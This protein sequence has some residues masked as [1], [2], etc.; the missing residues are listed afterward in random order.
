M[1]DAPELVDF[2]QQLVDKHE[3]EAVTMFVQVYS[4]YQTALHAS[5]LLDFDDLILQAILLLQDESSIRAQIQDRFC[6]ISVDEYQDTNLGQY[7][8]LRLLAGEKV[9]V[10][11]IGDPDQ[12]IYGF[13]GAN[14]EY[15]LRFHQ[16]FPGTHTLQLSQNYRSTQLILDA[17][18]QVIAQSEERTDSAR[19]QV[20]SEFQSDQA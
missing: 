10:C 7:R 16:D 13:R 18:S 17:S 3:L 9:N 20:W 6:W 19:V 4:S 1:P 15:F 2:A 8:L 11:A 5:Q 12:A 14:R